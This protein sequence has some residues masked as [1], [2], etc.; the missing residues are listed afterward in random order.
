MG[1]NAVSNYN[2][3]FA[4]LAVGWLRISMNLVGLNGDTPFLW[5]FFDG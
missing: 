4:K 2:V 1:Q 3:P 5:G